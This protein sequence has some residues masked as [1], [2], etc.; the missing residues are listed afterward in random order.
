MIMSTSL[1][2]IPQIDTTAVTLGANS[3]ASSV[4]WQRHEY[5]AAL[6]YV[7]LLAVTVY[8]VFLLLA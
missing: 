6:E 5:A 4:G 8:G 7:F 2:A 3:G 1:G